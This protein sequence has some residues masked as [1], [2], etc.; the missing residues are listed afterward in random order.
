MSDDTK[1]N[2][3]NIQHLWS[4]NKSGDVKQIEEVK[5]IIMPEER[6]YK[7][8]AFYMETF[9]LDELILEKEYNV[10]DLKLMIALKRRLDFNNRIKTFRQK[11]IAEEI[12]SSQ[13]NVSKSL[14]KLIKDKIIYKDGL[15]FYFSDKYIKFSGDKRKKG[16]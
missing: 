3:N 8:G 6:H 13:S 11:E 2:E 14:K 5:K 15:D 10:V 12:K 9:I 4:F 1:D 7:K 16:K